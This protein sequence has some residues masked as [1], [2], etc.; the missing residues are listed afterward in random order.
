MAGQSGNDDQRAYRVIRD[1][2]HDYV[3]LPLE[4]NALLDDPLVQRLRRVSQTSLSASVYPSMTGTRFEHALGTM[5]L[6][7][8]G[9]E[10]LWARSHQA[11]RKSFS[12]EVYESLNKRINLLDDR[13]RAWVKNASVYEEEFAHVLGL[14]IGTAALLHDV[15]H[16]PFSHALEGFFE[17]NLAFILSDGPQIDWKDKFR[18]RL[19]PDPSFPRA[20]HERVGIEF[21]GQIDPKRTETL[22]WYLVSSIYESAEPWAKAL[23]EIIDSDVDVDRLDYLQRDALRAG[24]EFGSIDRQRLVDSIELHSV[25]SPDGTKTWKLGYGYRARTAIETLLANRVR[26]YQWVLFHP[27]VAAANKFLDL[28][29]QH[30]VEIAEIAAKTDADETA[31]DRSVSSAIDSRRPDLNYLKATQQPARR[32][33]TLPAGPIRLLDPAVERRQATVDDSTIIEWAKSAASASRAAR[34]YDKISAGLRARLDRFLALFE[35][36]FFRASNW[37]PVWKTEDQYARVATLVAPSLI[38]VLSELSEESAEAVKIRLG[39]LASSAEPTS[40]ENFPRPPTVGAKRIAGRTY[41]NLIEKIRADPA[42]GLNAVAD[43][44]LGSSHPERRLLDERELATRLGRASG[45]VAGFAEGFWVFAYDQVSALREGDSGIVV[46]RSDQPLR[47]TQLSSMVATLPE[48]SRAFPRFF[49]YYIGADNADM[50]IGRDSVHGDE[51]RADFVRSFAEAVGT[52]L[53]A[54]VFR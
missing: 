20:F 24:T 15:G 33:L 30:L 19:A 10:S 44:I 5:H 38:E 13:T 21:L 43:L 50:R 47:L 32:Q 40:S 11:T 14:A 3:Q 6:A 12:K 35:A 37:A 51:I 29:L 31:I 25:L 17:R 18:D 16:T 53:R 8:R 46:W 54:R 34:S 9:W 2:V 1:P 22:P 27:H 36:V 41:E 7:M 23:H 28:A 52:T 48:I 42:D 49:A 26:Y 4:M 45:P 39:E